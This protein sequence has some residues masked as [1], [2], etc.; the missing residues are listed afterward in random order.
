MKQVF[1]KI[2]VI[3]ALLGVMLVPLSSIALAS[4][5]LVDINGQ[6]CTGA[7]VDTPGSTSSCD[8]SGGG[9]TLQKA[10]AQVINV[11]SWIVG[12]VAVI[13]VMIGGFQYI[14]AGGN[15]SNVS[16]AKNTILFAVIGLVVVAIA[17]LL[18]KFVI[19]KAGNL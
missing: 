1:K 7:N 19:N 10:V 15:D 3:V 12:V 4:T 11:F 5:E 2:A 14:T 13:M 18:V 6:I 8:S 16:K 9:S 17:Q